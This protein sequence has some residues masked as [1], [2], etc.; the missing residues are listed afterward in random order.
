MIQDWHF[1]YFNIGLYTQEVSQPKRR[2]HVITEILVSYDLGCLKECHN[3]RNFDKQ[4]PTSHFPPACLHQNL[5]V[6]NIKINSTSPKGKAV[7]LW[8]NAWRRDIKVMPTS[9]NFRAKDTRQ[10]NLLIEHKIVV[11]LRNL[12]GLFC[13]TGKGYLKSLPRVVFL[14]TISNWCFNVTSK[15]C[16]LCPAV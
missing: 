10:Q 11:Y 8:T 14:F 7:V 15:V 12:E 5:K 6:K 16:M 2:T 13:P 1:S 3:L 9:Q 4:Q